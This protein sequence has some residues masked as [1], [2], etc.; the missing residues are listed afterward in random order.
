MKP[1]D[2]QLPPTSRS[3]F[4]A[5][6]ALLLLA[7]STAA[8]AS[9]STESFTEAMH[10][11]M[12]RMHR[13]MSGSPSGNVDRDFAA[14]M[15]PHHQGAVDMAVLQLQHGSDERLRRLAHG[16]IVE[17]QQEIRVM[18]NVLAELERGQPLLAEGSA[19]PHHGDHQ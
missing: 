4:R 12:V 13:D 18:R 14:M 15:I 1:N 2:P 7:G 9:A 6:A 17:Q 11:A 10:D 19:A 5:I 3:G 16:I 8:L